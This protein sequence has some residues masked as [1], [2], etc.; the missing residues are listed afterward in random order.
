MSSK[1]ITPGEQSTISLDETIGFIETN[2]G[3][4]ISHIE[5]GP[6]HTSRVFIGSVAARQFT[7]GTELFYGYPETSQADLGKRV[8]KM[9][10]TSVPQNRLELANRASDVWNAADIR[11]DGAVEPVRVQ[12]YLATTASNQA[13]Q[14]NEIVAWHTS[15]SNPTLRNPAILAEFIPGEKLQGDAPT[16]ALDRL[17]ELHAKVHGHSRNPALLDLVEGRPDLRIATVNDYMDRFTRQ[18]PEIIAQM[19]DAWT[20]IVRAV[21]EALSHPNLPQGIVPVSYWM[22]DVMFEG[23]RPKGLIDINDTEYTSPLFCLGMSLWGLY[24]AGGGKSLEPI[25][26]YMSIYNQH[27][28]LTPLEQKEWPRFMLARAITSW[29]GAMLVNVQAAE[30]DAHLIQ[31]LFVDLNRAG[32]LPEG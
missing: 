8:M 27:R 16:I 2:W 21:D 32:L 29:Q 22:G 19:P 23:N 4:P 11:I 7:T 12:S 14:H 5:E 1:H 26:R 3:V 28:A 18:S 17:A 13:G 24:V 15:S 25:T 10:P 31:K 9:F 30:R 6:S 20:A